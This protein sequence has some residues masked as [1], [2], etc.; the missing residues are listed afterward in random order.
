VI[1]AKFQNFVKLEYRVLHFW[2]IQRKR[3]AKQY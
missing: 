2:Q 3:Y 1:S